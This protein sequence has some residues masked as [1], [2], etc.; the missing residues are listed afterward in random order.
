VGLKALEASKDFQNNLKGHRV[1]VTYSKNS[2]K[3]LVEKVG[4]GDN[5]ETS[6]RK[7]KM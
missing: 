7:D 1:L 5:E 6:K 2:K 3:C 4:L